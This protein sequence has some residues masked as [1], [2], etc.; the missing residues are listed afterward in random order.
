MI[1]GTAPV[2]MLEK[3]EEAVNRPKLV[4]SYPEAVSAVGYVPDFPKYTQQDDV[5]RPVVVECGGVVQ[6]PLQL[7][8][9]ILHHQLIQQHAVLF[10]QGHAVL[11]VHTLFINGR[12]VPGGVKDVH[13]NERA[14][15]LNCTAPAMTQDTEMEVLV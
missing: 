11:H 4:Y 10:Q 7:V 9:P 6:V 2:N 5:Q 3:P 13:Q 15:T 12:I 8:C 1:F 14:V